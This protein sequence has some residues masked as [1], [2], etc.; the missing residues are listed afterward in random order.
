MTDPFFGPA[1]IDADEWRDAPIRH[2]YVHGGFEG[3]DTRFAFYFPETRFYDGRFVQLLEGGL[4]G[5]EGDALHSAAMIGPTVEWLAKKFGAYFIE[6]NQGHIGLDP[7]P[8]DP[9]ITTYRA[10]AESARYARSLATAMYGWAPHHGY[11]VG[12]SGGGIRTWQCM[13]HVHDVWDGGVPFVAG[14]PEA[15]SGPDAGPLAAAVAGLLGPKLAGVVD[16]LEPGG[17]DPFAGLND[18]EQ[19]SLRSLFESTGFPRRGLFQHTRPSSDLALA[20]LFIAGLA[21]PAFVEDFWTT[22]G[23]AGADGELA[24]RLVEEKLVI[25]KVLSVDELNRLGITD[26]AAAFADSRSPGEER[27]TSFEYVWVGL[28][29]ASPIPPDTQFATLRITTGEA[30]GKQLVCYGTFGDVVVVGGSGMYHARDLAPGDEVVIDNRS[31]LAACHRHLYPQRRPAELHLGSTRVVNL[32]MCGRFHGKMIMVNAA[33]DGLATPLNGL[34]YDR[35]VRAAYGAAAEDRWRLW[36]ADNSGHTGDSG[37][38][39]PRPVLQTRVIKY[40]G[41]VSQALSDLV[42]WVER[43]IEPPA[44]TSYRFENGQLELPSSASE[45][46]GVQPVVVATANGGKRAEVTVGE[47]VVF[48]AVAEA[49][50]GG[51]AIVGVEW[52]FDGTGLFAVKQSDVGTGRTAVRVRVAQR[53]DVAGTFFPAVRVIARRPGDEDWSGVAPA[54]QTPLLPTGL[55]NLDRVRVV[56]R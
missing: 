27:A 54:A 5:H 16:A 13:E 3:T 12:P 7:G 21:D 18:A 22:P 44:S 42:D 11:L 37:L 28:Q 17:G 10:N 23:Y 9:T 51:G 35:K 26:H 53:F 41:I 32:P 34:T 33:L 31:Y 45:R 30:T 36:W 38:P 2:R 48:E 40:G 25:T 29:A 6:C 56:V 47:E 52:D 15:V 50:D 14:D 19:E 4:G 49:P 39:G 55:L 8:S 46:H 20:P 43:G 1:F 24:D